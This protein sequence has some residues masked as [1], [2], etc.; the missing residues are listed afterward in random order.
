LK[1]RN[2]LL[3]AG[4]VLLALA[5]AEIAVRLFI[6]VRMVGPSFTVY[7]PVYGKRLKKNF[8][9]TRV[10]PEFTIAFSTNSHGFRGPGEGVP[11]RPILFLGDSFTMGYGVSDGEE[12]PALVRAAL[13]ERE[14][15]IPVVNTGMGANGNGRWIKFLRAE[16]R[17]YDP[18]VVILQLMSNDFQDNL[19]E[20]LFDVSADGQLIELPVPPIGAIR[21]LQNAVDSVP[22]LA[23]SHLLGL[24]YQAFLTIEWQKSA[25]SAGMN[26]PGPGARD[27]DRLTYRILDE[28]IAICRAHDWPVIAIQVGIHGKRLENIRR[29]L[30]ENGIRLIDT[31]DRRDRPDLYYATDGHWNR[32]GHAWVAGRVLA[33]LEKTGVL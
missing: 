10:T 27:S 24:I 26:D 13:A 17:V 33:E 8:T 18:R 21:V 30:R 12:F 5:L 29:Q 9:T 4:S 25:A 31:P 11:V 14:P 3:L 19:N 28:A 23:Y 7:D 2:F 22:G 20:R 32:A 6:P 15:P 1:G 16:G